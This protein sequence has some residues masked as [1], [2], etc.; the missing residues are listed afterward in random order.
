ERFRTIKICPKDLAC[1]SRHSRPVKGS[2]A[3]QGARHE[4]H[5]LEGGPGEAGPHAAIGLRVGGGLCNRDYPACPSVGKR[6]GVRP[7]GSWWEGPAQ[8]HAGAMPEP[9]YEPLK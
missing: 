2:L 3:T 6:S 8:S 7:A 9:A 5:D 1:V 4:R